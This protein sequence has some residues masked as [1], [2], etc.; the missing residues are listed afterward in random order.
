MEK[1]VTTKCQ[2]HNKD[3]LYYDPMSSKMLCFR[4]AKTY[5][6]NELLDIEECSN[7]VLDKWSHF[8]SIMDHF[9]AQAPSKM[10]DEE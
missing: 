2:V 9:F 7:T 8:L 3:I 6:T 5:D 10:H 4:C 1:K